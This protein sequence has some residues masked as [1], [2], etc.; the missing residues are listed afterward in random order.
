MK[1]QSLVLVSTIL[2]GAM[3]TAPVTFAQVKNGKGGGR[4][5]YIPTE[6]ETTKLAN[7]T[8]VRAIRDKG[9]VT[10]DEPDNPFDKTCQDCLSTEVRAADGTL[11]EQ[12][13]HCIGIDGDG[14]TWSI[15]FDGGSKPSKWGILG[16]TGK[17]KGLEGG[18]TTK[19]ER[20]WPDG[21][22][23]ITWEGSWQ[24]K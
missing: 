24:T 5:M 11:L 4:G 14:D 2:A 22:W 7:G 21:R 20:T 17:F 8:T 18:G 23:I 19:L 10:G 15:W 3:A 6:I 1:I 12:K 9:F 13:G 16:G